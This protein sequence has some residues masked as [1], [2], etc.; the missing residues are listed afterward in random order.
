MTDAVDLLNRQLSYQY[1]I[2]PNFVRLV[3]KDKNKEIKS[4]DHTLETEIL[5]KSL[6]EIHQ[7]LKTL[8]ERKV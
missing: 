8:N 6:K 1:N 5:N 3:S 2:Q 4:L 7:D